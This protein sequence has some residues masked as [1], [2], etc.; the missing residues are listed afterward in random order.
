MLPKV[1]LR[2]HAQPFWKLRTSQEACSAN[3][4]CKDG[5]GGVPREVFPK[6][7]DRRSLLFSFV[8]LTAWWKLFLRAQSVMSARKAPLTLYDQVLGVMGPNRGER[9]CSWGKGIHLFTFRFWEH[10]PSF[11]LLTFLH[12]GRV[13][14]EGSAGGA[15]ARALG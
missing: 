4:C 14:G 13:C 9:P 3:V 8:L 1:W 11:N 7:V 12:Q 5:G 10:S 15:E 6:S 2:E